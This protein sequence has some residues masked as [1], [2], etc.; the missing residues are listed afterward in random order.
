MRASL[1]DAQL[2]ALN[3][4]YGPF[5][6]RAEW[7]QY[8]YVDK[9]VDRSGVEIEEVLRGLPLGL[10]IPDP[11]RPSF[12]PQPHD[13]LKLTI[14][15]IALC[16]GSEPDLDLFIRA[17]RFFV[18]LEEG[19]E[20][21]PSGGGS[22]RVASSELQAA[23]GISTDQLRRIYHLVSNEIGILGSGGGDPDN[24]SFE[25]PARIRRFRGVKTIDDYL[26]RRVVPPAYPEAAAVGLVVE[27]MAPI[28][29]A[30]EQQLA[31]RH[32]VLALLA[33][34]TAHPVI[35]GLILI[36]VGAAVALLFGID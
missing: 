1:S 21:P 11:A 16:E 28:V 23:L 6:G 26:E 17:L 12:F 24:W 27:R 29:D 33:A 19:H 10:M 2:L 34:I 35:S 18:E 9:V 8:A 3:A 13:K 14:G 15:G 22:L 7:P 30:L 4:T 36:V 31:P 25:I 5:R 32:R 20:P